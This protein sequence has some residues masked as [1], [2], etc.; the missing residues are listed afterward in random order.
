MAILV[1]QVESG[2]SIEVRVNPGSR[3]DRILGEKDG[4][5]RVGVTAAPERGKANQA[6]VRYLAKR[7]GVR[8]SA[9]R[10]AAGERDRRKVV[11]FDGLDPET[12]EA[13]LNRCLNDE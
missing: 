7:L 12:L 13:A 5:L 3:G 11:V 2:S 10:V 1:R 9:V 8:K 6:L 4:A